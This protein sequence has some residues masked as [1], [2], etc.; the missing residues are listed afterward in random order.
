MKIIKKPPDRK[1]A[2]LTLIFPGPEEVINIFIHGYNAVTSQSK[3]EKLSYY[4]LSAKPAGRI[5]L[6]YWRAGNWRLPVWTQGMVT[7]SKTAY[8]AFRV[9]KIFSPISLLA[10]AAALTASEM[11]SYRYYERRAEK[12]GDYLKSHI[13]TIPQ[14]SDYK[15]NLIGHSLGA[16]VIYYALSLHEWPDYHINDCIFLGGAADIEADWDVFLTRIRGKIYNAYSRRDLVLKITPDMR[17]RVGRY[18]IP[19]RSSRIINQDCPS[20]QHIDYWPELGQLLPCLWENF[21]PSPYINLNHIH[22]EIFF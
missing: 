7:I 13:R 1:N 17:K 15:I 20:F 3:F 11:L 19:A 14:A 8:R 22:P 12:L 6:L 21:R 9:G 5:Y 16:R 10:D 2:K 4:I 18:P